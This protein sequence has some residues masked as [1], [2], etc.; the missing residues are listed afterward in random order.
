MYRQTSINEKRGRRVTPL[1]SSTGC[2][3][4]FWLRKSGKN[5]TAIAPSLARAIGANPDPTGSHA[6]SA[7][8]IGSAVTLEQPGSAYRPARAFPFA[9]LE[10]PKAGSDLEL[11]R[12][13][14]AHEVKAT[15]L[16]E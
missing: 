14:L 8:C 16:R 5:G 9:F 12:R 6:T 7:G 3:S 10:A 11:A 4:Y 15:K 1:L 2:F 13:N